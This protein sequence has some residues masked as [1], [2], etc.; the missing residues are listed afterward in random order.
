MFRNYF[1]NLV[2]QKFIPKII[3]LKKLTNNK[4]FFKYKQDR[5]KGDAITMRKEK[6]YTTKDKQNI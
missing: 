1:K 2:K 4:L 6:N 5:N 3:Y